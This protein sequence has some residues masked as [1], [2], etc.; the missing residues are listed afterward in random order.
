MGKKTDHK[1]KGCVKMTKFLGEPSKCQTCLLPKC[2]ED[3]H[4]DWWDGLSIGNDIGLL[5]GIRQGARGAVHAINR[6][7]GEG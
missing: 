2:A 6:Y 4:F 1:D 3:K 5:D 7:G